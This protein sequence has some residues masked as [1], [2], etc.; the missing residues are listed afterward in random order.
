M[1][2]SKITHFFLLF[3]AEKEQLAKPRLNLLFK[4]VNA[5]V[6]FGFLI[7]LT[8]DDQERNGLMGL[9]V[10]AVTTRP[11]V[12]RKVYQCNKLSSMVRKANA[13]FD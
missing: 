11:V 8:K 5:K 1:E 2:Q 7:S 9:F 6:Q 4:P 3:Y 13:S 10:L 12:T